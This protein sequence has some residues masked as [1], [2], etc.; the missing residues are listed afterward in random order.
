[1]CLQKDLW[2]DLTQIDSE[3][4]NEDIWAVHRTTWGS[5]A[6][7]K[8]QETASYPNAKQLPSGKL[9]WKWKIQHPQTAYLLRMLISNF[10]VIL[11]LV[12]QTFSQVDLGMV[13]DVEISLN[14]AD[15]KIHHGALTP[16][17]QLTAH[18]AF[19][20]TELLPLDIGLRHPTVKLHRSLFRSAVPSRGGWE[21]HP[22][23]I[24]RNGSK[25]LYSKT[26]M[27]NT[28]LSSE[29]WPIPL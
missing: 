11:R 10:Q 17:S 2:F 22:S 21:I 19:Y 15:W 27:L 29:R 26:S 18:G 20:A 14:K 16:K 13:W 25:L 3:T 9:S 5:P 23:Q 24:L 1:M 4:A 8:H 12:Y 28:E 6:T 7:K